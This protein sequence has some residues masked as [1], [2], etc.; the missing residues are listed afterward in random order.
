M[1]KRLLVLLSAVQK[2]DEKNIALNYKYLVLIWL[3]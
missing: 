1:V 2:V 3:V